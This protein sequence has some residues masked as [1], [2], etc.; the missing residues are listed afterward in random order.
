[1]DFSACYVDTMSSVAV[2]ARLGDRRRLRRLLRE[3]RSVSCTDN[4][5]W[6]PLHEAA[7]AGMMSCLKDILSAARTG[8]SLSE[9]RTYVN[10]STHEGET[11]CFLAARGGH[12]GAVR[13]LLKS[14]AKIDQLTNDLSCP[15]YAAVDNGHIEV[16]RL[17]MDKGAELNRS[18]TAT[19]WTCLHLA[20]YR[21]HVDI[22]RMLVQSAEL[23]VRDDY[24][25][26]PLF[27]AAKHGRQQCL[28][29][30]IHA[31]ADVNA[32][33]SDM[34]SPLMLASQQGH[35]SCVELLLEHN[36][37]ANLNCS[38]DWPQ[39]P[40]HAAAQF[41]HLGILRRLLPVTIRQCDRGEGLVSPLYLAIQGGQA[42]CVALLLDQGFSPDAQSRLHS[43]GPHSP[44]SLA[45]HSGYSDIS[46]M[47]LAAGAALHKWEWKPVL[48]QKNSSLLK[49]VLEHRWLYPPRHPRGDSSKVALRR[50]EL[51]DML[52][53]ALKLLE[54]AVDWL[55]PLLRAGL[56]PD[57]LLRSIVLEKVDSELLNFLLQFVNWS[58]MSPA[59]KSVLWRRRAQET[60]HPLPQFDSV[61]D[62]SH[63]CRLRIRTLMGPEEVMRTDAVGELP[64]PP[65]IQ[66]FL[67]FT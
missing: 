40:I 53:T 22:V 3:G 65:S 63:L 38:Y 16:V 6:M 41:G 44:L 54:F 13:R 66:R 9:F 49:L 39:L 2:A 1:M 37:N 23:E 64:V 33:A 26:T 21:D 27:L 61:P 58:T 18:H 34:A 29:I 56:D 48:G 19:C 12:V 20:V 46:G 51:D 36:A 8:V 32:Q 62:L 24:N 25:M 10:S 30:L 50:P 5:G 60:W 11:A 55:P 4:R 67:Q 47:L 28:E 42:A 59:L 31:G 52:R 45:F 43:M 57:S 15:L 35:E 7:H 14:K 17:L